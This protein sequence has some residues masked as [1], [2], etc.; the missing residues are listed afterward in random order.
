MTCVPTITHLFLDNPHMT[1]AGRRHIHMRDP[2]QVSIH[3]QK[4]IQTPI[5]SSTYPNPPMTVESAPAEEIVQSKLNVSREKHLTARRDKA[6]AR[7]V[8]G[9]VQGGRQLVQHKMHNDTQLGG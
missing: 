4:Q 5:S 2:R 1:L 3:D 7:L 8:A 6:Q 9:L